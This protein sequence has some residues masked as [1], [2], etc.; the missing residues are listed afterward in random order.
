MKLCLM[1]I[2]HKNKACEFLYYED[3]NCWVAQKRIDIGNYNLF[4]EIHLK[5][6]QNTEFDWS[7]VT[8]FLTYLENKLPQE[9]DAHAKEL[10][11]SVSKIN[12]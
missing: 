10:L 2:E 6:F 1:A 11:N 9:S 4:V 12:H 8:S 7:M 5:D 3:E